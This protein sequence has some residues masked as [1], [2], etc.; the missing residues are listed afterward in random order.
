MITCGTEADNA[1]VAELERALKDAHGAHVEVAHNVDDEPEEDMPFFEVWLE[2]YRYVV[3]HS[4]NWHEQGDLTTEKIQDI[5]KIVGDEI[6]DEARLVLG[7]Y[8]D[9]ED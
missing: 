9:I 2:G 6:S 5:V 8:P 3:L 1:T 7:T 4:R